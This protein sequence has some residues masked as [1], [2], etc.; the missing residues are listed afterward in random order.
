MGLG[1]LIWKT[2]CIPLGYA[3]CL[4]HDRTSK[5]PLHLSAKASELV[6]TR[7][8]VRIPLGELEFSF[9]K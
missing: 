4:S 9:S 5:S 2:S 8:Q 1:S 7:P 3:G 6:A